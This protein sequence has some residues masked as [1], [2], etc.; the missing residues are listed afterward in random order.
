MLLDSL[1]KEGRSMPE[2]NNPDNVAKI[3]LGK[4]R[5]TVLSRMVMFLIVTACIFFIPAGT[6]Q[7]WE[8]WAYIAILFLP[9]SVM[10]LYL[11]KNDPEL[12]DRRM[13]MKEKQPEQKKII[14]WSYAFFILTFL[15]PG[16]D[17]R[18]GWS[19]VH[20]AIIIAA[21][22]FILV[23]YLLLVRVLL[24]NRYASRIIEVA[25]KQKVIATGPYAIVRHPMYSSVLLIYG[26]S[27]LALGSYWA[28]IPTVFIIISLI[29]RILNEEKLLLK[30][31]DG[32]A[33]YTKKTRYRM[34]PG[35]W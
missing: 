5:K 26:F 11:L 4:L 31:L 14:K 28:L 22:V 35:I 12:L 16:F 24:E 2:K 10:M 21:D 20:L 23:G 30:E 17:R 32:Y 6:L 19:S 33:E 7:Y 18:F 15:I 13:R 8:A 25:E 34:I 27:P 29:A 1:S 9:A 3:D